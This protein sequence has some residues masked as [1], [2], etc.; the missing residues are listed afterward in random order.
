M[1]SSKFVSMLLPSPFWPRRTN[2]NK[3]P[4]LVVVISFRSASTCRIIRASRSE[5]CDSSSL[6]V[7][8]K[9]SSYQTVI[10]FLIFCQKWFRIQEHPQPAE[11]SSPSSVELASEVSWV[12]E[13]NWSNRFRT[14]DFSE[15]S[16]GILKRTLPTSD[17]SSS[18]VSGSG[19]GAG[20]FEMGLRGVGGATVFFPGLV[21]TRFP[22]SLFRLLIARF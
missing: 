9:L 17:A 22:S 21:N 6:A 7:K 3:S 1:E 19:T 12:R 8:A 4:S 10:D 11:S 5:S 15:V 16:T 2:E 13:R 18:L 20:R 14:F